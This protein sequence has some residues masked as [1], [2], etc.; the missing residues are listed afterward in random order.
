[1]SASSPLAR[2][3]ASRPARAAVNAGFH[4]FSRR[5]VARLEWTDPVDTQRRTLLRLVRHAR[6]TRFGGDHHFAKV[7]TVEDFQDAVPL[8][9]YE[10][11]WR[12]YFRDQ[13]PI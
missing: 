11:V 2:L 1:M 7:R 4:A 8:R 13:Y 3:S 6:R 12:L 5:R 9:T 10:D